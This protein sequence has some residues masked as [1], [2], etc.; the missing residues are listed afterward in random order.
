MH[1]HLT[2]NNQYSKVSIWY[3]K[4]WLGGG[5]GKILGYLMSWYFLWKLM[6]WIYFQAYKNFA[7]IAQD[8]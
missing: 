7:T 1:I 2:T 4:T 8:L 6:I 3:N 5:R